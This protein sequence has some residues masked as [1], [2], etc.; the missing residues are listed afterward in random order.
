MK[1]I[2]NAYNE[3][4]LVW[5]F[6]SKYVGPLNHVDHGRCWLNMFDHTKISN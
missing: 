5:V 3:G 6:H 1:N 2:L 4:E